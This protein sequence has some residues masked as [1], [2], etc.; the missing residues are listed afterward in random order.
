MNLLKTLPKVAAYALALITG[1]L[2]LLLWRALG[3]DVHWLAI[4][5][6]AGEVLW[7]H[8]D[9]ANVHEKADEARDDADKAVRRADEARGD[10]ASVVNDLAGKEPPGTGKHAKSASPAP[11]TGRTPS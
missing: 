1:G 6:L 9:R 11:S 5:V 8:L 7:L 3:F 10:V 4:T 2:V